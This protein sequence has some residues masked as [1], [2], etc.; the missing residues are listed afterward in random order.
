MVGDDAIRVHT[1][2]YIACGWMAGARSTWCAGW[3]D[4]EGCIVAMV[5]NI[6]NISWKCKYGTSTG[7][8]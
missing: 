2:V 4:K 8:R 3:R 1:C 5:G 7:Y 6:V